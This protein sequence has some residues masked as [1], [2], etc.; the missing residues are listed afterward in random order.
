M[1][2]YTFEASQTELGVFE[3]FIPSSLSSRL[4]PPSLQQTSNCICSLIAAI[5][6]SGALKTPPESPQPTAFLL[7]SASTSRKVKIKLVSFTAALE[8]T[9]ANTPKN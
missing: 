1:I 5:G 2:L 6:E 7:N 3:G 8:H 9:K 4:H